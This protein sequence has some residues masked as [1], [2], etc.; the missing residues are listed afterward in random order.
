[1]LGLCKCCLGRSGLEKRCSTAE[2]LYDLAESRVDEPEAT[3]RLLEEPE[4][5]L[6]SLPEDPDP[7][8]RAQLTVSSVNTLSDFDF[9]DRVQLTVSS[10]NTFLEALPETEDE[11][12]RVSLGHPKSSEIG[13]NV[14]GKKPLEVAPRVPAE[15][16]AGRRPAEK[17]PEPV[18]R[19][20]DSSRHPSTEGPTKTVSV[21][22][23]KLRTGG[24]PL[25]HDLPSPQKGKDRDRPACVTFDAE[26]L[27]AD[28]TP[29]CLRPRSSSDATSRLRTSSVVEWHKNKLAW[30]KEKRDQ[31]RREAPS[32]SRPRPDTPPSA[33]SPSRGPVRP[34]PRGYSTD[35]E[36]PP[37]RSQAKSVRFGRAP[38]DPR[39]VS[40]DWPL[41]KLGKLRRKGG[42][43][44]DFVPEQ[45]AVR[46]A[47]I[48]ALTKHE[49]ARFAHR[50]ETGVRSDKSKERTGKPRVAFDKS[51][52]ASANASWWGKLFFEKTKGV[53]RKPRSS[54]DQQTGNRP[55][56]H[57]ILSTQ[58]NFY[59]PRTPPGYRS[60]PETQGCIAVDAP[61]SLRPSGKFDEF[62]LKSFLRLYHVKL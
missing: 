3:E 50:L 62:Y 13:D 20:G 19:S 39:L 43:R 37:S 1:M 49:V 16:P 46:S 23:N 48:A 24:T 32:S 51:H 57:L 33:P 55:R 30:L 25:G 31:R 42:K 21:L 40:F 36:L 44:D 22:K 56:I 41:G 7:D 2:R 59:L 5:L 27:G 6:S 4:T 9:L 52:S 18:G 60:R 8:D 53:K 10:A 45:L 12:D 15:R 61:Q 14:A 38:K 54:A 47:S 29:G 35:E 58:A 28:R 11:S 17:R 34:D 26:T